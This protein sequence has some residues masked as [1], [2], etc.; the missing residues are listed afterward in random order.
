MIGPLPV[1][2][3]GSYT[4]GICKV[5]YELSRQKYEGVELYVSSTNIPQTG[6]NKICEF[7]RQYNGYRF[8]LFDILS[9]VIL[10]PMRTLREIKFYHSNCH[11]NPIRYEFYKV[12]IRRHIKYIKPDIIHVHTTECPAAFFANS[13]HVPMIDTMHGMFYRGL[14]SQYKLGD[15]L[16][17]CVGICDFFTGLTN[18]CEVY[19]RY[20]L[21]IPNNKITI[22]PNGVNTSLYFFDSERRSALRNKYNV[23]DS[24]I[25]IT[26]ASVQERKGQFRFLKL[27]EKLNLDYQYWILGEGPDKQRIIDYCINKGISDRVICFGHINSSELYMFYS[28]ADVYA[29]V[30][31]MEGQALC[32]LEA[33]ATGIRTIVNKEI[34]DTIVTDINN[35]ENYFVID[36]DDPNISMLANWVEK[37]GAPRVSRVEMSWARVANMY[38]DLYKRIYKAYNQ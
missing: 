9:D 7:D 17:S 38:N 32:E 13:L 28:A 4:T 10:H 35:L 19:M 18:E 33:Y 20:Y 30:S 22:I 25:F 16:R 21:N 37:K 5:V 6:A 2:V 36:F 34:K 1:D 12:N 14:D 8:L 24:I 29:H 27:L 15:F 3:G 11:V 23:G 31:T 26:V